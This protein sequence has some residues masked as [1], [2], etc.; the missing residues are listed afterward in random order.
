MHRDFPLKLKS[1]EESGTFSGFGSTYGGV[2]LLG[3]T[4]AKGAFAQAIASQGSGYPL[5]WAHSQAEPIG[6]ARIS[7]SATGLI[8]NGTLVMADPAAQRAHA[9]LKAGSIRG[10]SIGFQIPDGKSETQRDGTRLLREI[11]LHEISLV[12]CPANP[13]AQVLSVKDISRV[14]GGLR[15]DEVP[16]DDRTVLLAA[17]KKLLGA[18][19]SMCQCDCPECLADDC[20]NC[21]NADCV[22]PNCE[23]TL[24]TLKALKELAHELRQ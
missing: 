6:V 11:R 17:L 12:A 13:L 7:D 4:I 14:L 22:D 20:V 5:L 16:A 18:K 10:L 24:A 3:D 9:H 23:G 19:D 15:V 2:D 1:L 8:V 21:S